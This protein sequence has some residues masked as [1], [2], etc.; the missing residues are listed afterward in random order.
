MKE[1]DNIFA[2][3]HQGKGTLPKVVPFRR[4]TAASAKPD[5]GRPPDPGPTAA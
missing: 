4:P 2:K 5:A 3:A 1:N